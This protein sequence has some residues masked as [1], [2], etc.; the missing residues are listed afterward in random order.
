MTKRTITSVVYVIVLIALVTLKWL[1]PYNFGA[2]GFDVLFTAISVIGAFELMRAAGCVCKS[3]KAVAY[4]YC[5]ALVPLYS[6]ACFL[7]DNGVVDIAY[8]APAAAAL[9]S[10][11]AVV[12]S[13]VMLVFDHNECT[14]KSTVYCMFTLLYCGFLPLTMSAVN[15]LPYNSTFAVLYMFIVVVFTDAGAFIF[16]KLLHNV[17][18]KKMAPHISPNKTVIGGIGGI[19]G[20]VVGAVAT[21]YFCYLLNYDFVY[22]GAVPL[23]VVLGL[24]SLLLGFVVQTGDLFES[25]IKRECDIKDMGNLLPGHGGMLDRFDSMLFTAPVI[26]LVFAVIAVL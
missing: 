19:L 15:H 25:A 1:V 22:N 14:F 8:F 11:L 20:A 3:Q 10:G 7:S 17:F 12:M 9:V 16:G 18:P 21:Y 2:I 26:L 13:A 6:I 5:A 24:F 23:A 4:V